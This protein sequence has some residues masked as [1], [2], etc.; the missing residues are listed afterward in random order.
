VRGTIAVGDRAAAEPSPLSGPLRPI[1]VAVEPVYRR[2]VARRN[3]RFDR[4]RGVVTLDRSVISVGNLTAGGTGKTPM[5]DRVVRWLIEAG[6]RPAI[7]MRGYGARASG[8]SDEAQLYDDAFEG[9]PVV[10]RPNRL[11]G[12]L[13]LFATPRGGAVDVVVLDDGFQHRRLARALDL[14]LVDATRDPAA[15]R[16]LPAG[17]L[18]E[19]IES[20]VRAGAVV[21]THADRATPSGLASV[22]RLVRAHTGADPVALSRHAWSGLRVRAPGAGEDE[23]RPASWLAGRRALAV[24]A[25]ARPESFF[26]SCEAA[27]A[28]LIERVALRD[29]DPYSTRTIEWL[30]GTL[31][32]TGAETLLVTEKDWTK[33][34]RVR[35]E[36]W[37]CPVAR[38][39]LTLGFE[40][41][42]AD[43]HAIVLRAA[44]TDPDEP[45]IRWGRTGMSQD[46]LPARSIS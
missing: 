34:R 5:V 44:S 42:G 2:V 25:L 4:G 11:D 18:R 31:E 26:A 32:R 28:R 35:P 14:V 20:L 39:V 22:E 36:L 46:G 21:L 10:A 33:L 24:C 19:P 3:A 27:G 17:W 7:A 37:P 45:A 13:A 15:D 23:Q 41:G 8:R 29:H 30:L 9:V 6:H 38:P 12:L 43:L 40:R 16:C 1:G